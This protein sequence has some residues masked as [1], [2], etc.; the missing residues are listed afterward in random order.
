MSMTFYRVSPIDYRS[1]REVCLQMSNMIDRR[2][3]E[4]CDQSYTKLRTSSITATIDSHELNMI[5][6]DRLEE[7]LIKLENKKID[8]FY[9]EF[10]LIGTSLRHPSFSYRFTLE[11]LKD[12]LRFYS[13]SAEDLTDTSLPLDL[14]LT[15]KKFAEQHPKVFADPKSYSRISRILMASGWFM[16]VI[17]LD[18]ARGFEP[19]DHTLALS[20]FMLAI[21][22][23]WLG[24]NL[25][26]SIVN[27]DILISVDYEGL[28]KSHCIPVATYTQ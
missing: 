20:A 25:F 4:I 6:F 3:E 22:V 12:K 18:S 27:N 7:F 15:A 23:Q 5:S 10:S 21:M 9:Y 1:L 26:Y 28:R 11:L 2:Y 14:D 8:R 24:G 17:A 16:P 19:G 13:Y